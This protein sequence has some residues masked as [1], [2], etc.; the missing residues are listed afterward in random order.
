MNAPRPV[1]LS[2]RDLAFGY[3]E[4]ERV[5]DGLSL[6]LREAE[7]CVVL[8]PN[9]AGKSTLL[10]LLAGILAPDRGAVV[11]GDGPIDDLRP[12]DRARRLAVVPQGLA[13]IPRVTVRDFVESGRYAHTTGFGRRSAADRRAVEQALAAVDL[14]GRGGAP[15]DELS[16]GQ[17][18]RALIG[19]A[20]AQE[21][22]V[23]LVDE[24]TSSLDLAHQLS[25]FELIAGLT[26]HDRSVLCVT[27][28]LNLASQFATR[29]VLLDEGRIVSEG[30]ASE[31]LTPEV[32][33]PV[34]GPRLRFG[35]LPAPHGKGAR[36]WVLPWGTR[37]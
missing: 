16:G 24:P 28:D 22:S 21:P 12:R 10:R 9:G 5:I 1:R 25:T 30:E 32:L 8:G 33:G 26:C 36:P 14:D 29:V 20:L 13:R 31:V 4:G 27:H 17:L 34:Y 2:A 18:Q 3:V 19:R 37:G 6:E 23:L 11:L 7:F 15:L 35:E